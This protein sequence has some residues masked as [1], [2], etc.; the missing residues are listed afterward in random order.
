M[1]KSTASRA[2][3]RFK[4]LCC[5][6]LGGEAVMPAL[7]NEMRG[8]LS[9]VTG[10]FFFNA[11]DGTA[12][13]VYSETA[14]AGQTY[15]TQFHDRRD[16]EI[17][18][19]G[20]D[21]WN[22]SEVGAHD[23]EDIL[24]IDTQTFRRTDFYN[25][26]YR[27]FGTDRLLRLVIRERG[28]ALGS[29]SLYRGGD[30][31]WTAADKRKLN[32]LE[33]FFV[34]VLKDRDVAEPAALADGVAEGIIIADADGRPVLLSGT[35]QRLL[36]LATH[37]RINAET[38]FAPVPTLPPPLVQIC[39]NLKR[40]FDDDPEAQA[41]IYAVR[42]NWG[43]FTFRAHWLGDADPQSGS[44]A[45]TVRHQEPVQIKLLRRAGELP[46][47]RRQA[48]VAFHLASGVSHDGIAE[49]LGISRNTAIAHGR[50]IYNKLDVHNRAELVNRLLT[51]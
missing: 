28:K 37:S 5:L 8:F 1:T 15:L 25:L 29:I 41:P 3:A 26:V 4:Q 20:W 23:L 36:V 47:S 38:R 43:G 13:N 42:N 16:Y 35:A 22:R 10:T 32:S 40:L 24:T 51:N 44:V 31:P 27:P 14:D 39:R 45:I 50:W 6:G 19:W 18:N 9:F 49:R 34:H 30:R 17:P 33:P 12:A 21:D 2:E 48:E 11:P 7:I 46:L